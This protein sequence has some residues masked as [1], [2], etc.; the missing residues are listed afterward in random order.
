M[1]GGQWDKVQDRKEVVRWWNWW[2]PSLLL[3]QMAAVEKTSRKAFYNRRVWLESNWVNKGFWLSCRQKRF[4]R[5]WIPLAWERK[6]QSFCPRNRKDS[7]LPL[8]CRPIFYF[9]DWR[10]AYKVEKKSNACQK[11]KMFRTGVHWS[12]LE[13]LLFLK[14]GVTAKKS[15]FFTAEINI[16]DL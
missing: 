5:I 15:D 7:H 6:A 4:F 3:S 9:T 14:G 11:L 2:D 8:L 12:K 13:M 10:V 1:A 16:F